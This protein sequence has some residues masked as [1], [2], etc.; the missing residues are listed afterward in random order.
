MRRLLPHATLHIYHGGHVA[1]V[2]DTEQI[3]PIVGEFLNRRHH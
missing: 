1:L 2:T 3:A